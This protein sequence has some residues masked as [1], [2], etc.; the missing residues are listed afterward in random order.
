MDGQKEDQAAEENAALIFLR[1]NCSEGSAGVQGN[2]SKP[3]G[4][5]AAEGGGR[6]DALR[7]AWKRIVR[8]SLSTLTP[9]A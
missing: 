3:A 7:R 5:A 2:F 1:E 9:S 8:S 6:S 4:S